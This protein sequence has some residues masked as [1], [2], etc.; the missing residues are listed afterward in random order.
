MKETFLSLCKDIT[1]VER[2]SQLITRVRRSIDRY[3]PNPVQYYCVKECVYSCMMN[4]SSLKR[5]T[6]FTSLDDAILYINETTLS[7]CGILNPRYENATGVYF[8]G[9]YQ[10]TISGYAPISIDLS[11]EVLSALSY[12]HEYKAELHTQ[13]KKLRIRDLPELF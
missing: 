8:H 5:L 13:Y 12:F 6:L 10:Q 2:I 7:H 1:F 11:I 9:R 3:C 4:S